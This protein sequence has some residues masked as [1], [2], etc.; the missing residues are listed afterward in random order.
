MILSMGIAG[1]G[2]ASAMGFYRQDAPLPTR[3]KAAFPGLYRVL[4]QKYYVDELYDTAVIRP[5]VSVSRGFLWKFFD[6]NVIDGT[7]NGLASAVRLCGMALRRLQT[8][9]V[10][11]YA[12]FIVLGALAFVFYVMMMLSKGL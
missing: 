2:I 12:Y 11:T 6:V 9:L 3:M 5:L 4:Y 1:L 8:G 10:H 7:V